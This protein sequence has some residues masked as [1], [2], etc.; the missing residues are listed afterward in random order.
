MSAPLAGRLSIAVNGERSVPLAVAS[1][2]ERATAPTEPR[3]FALGWIGTR[4]AAAERR[5]VTVLCCT[6][7]DRSTA[8]AAPSATTSDLDGTAHQKQSVR[9]LVEANGGYV[10]Q[11]AGRTLLAVWGFPRAHPDMTRLALSAAIAIPAI[12]SPI[13]TARVTLDA[14]LI[15]IS[16][17]DEAGAQTLDLTG[18]T[19]DAAIAMQ[20]HCPDGRV[21][22]SAAM[23]DL[24]HH[25][26]EYRPAA[27]ATTAMAAVFEYTGPGAKPGADSV[28]CLIGHDAARTMLRS[29]IASIA[30]GNSGSGVLV[31]G[32]AG[33]GKSV[34]IDEARRL[35]AAHSALWIEADCHYETRSV[36]LQPVRE[37]LMRLLSQPVSEGSGVDSMQAA[38]E[39]KLGRDGW[40][41]LTRFLHANSKRPATDPRHRSGDTARPMDLV[42]E[43]VVALT[44]AS[45]VVVAVEDLHWADSATIEFVE[46]IA[47]RLAGQA[48]L[49][50]VVSSRED[51]SAHQGAGRPLRRVTVQ[52]LCHEQ[53]VQVAAARSEARHLPDQALDDIARRSEGV[54]LYAIEL[55]RFHAASGPMTGPMAPLDSPSG[56]HMLF[57]ARLD[58]LGELKPLVQA[59]AIIGRRFET[60]ALAQLLGVSRGQLS[61]ALGG[62]VERGVIE[63]D[64]TLSFAAF[65]FTH[66]L[67]RDAAYATIPRELRDEMHQRAAAILAEGFHPDGNIASELI[68]SHFELACD[69][70]GA[71]RWWRSAAEAAIAI[72][73][74]NGAIGH[75]RSALRAAEQA[76]MAISKACRVDTMRLLAL[77]LSIVKG[78][79]SPEAVEA[80]QRCLDLAETNERDAPLVDFD[81]LWGLHS[82]Y[83]VRGDIPDA[84]DIGKRLLAKV[85]DDA[86][87]SQ[88]LL[89]HRIN[90][91]TQL[92]AGQLC[93]AMASYGRVLEIYRPERDARLRFEYGSDQRA[94]ALTH[95]AWAATIMG[96]VAQARADRAAALRAVRM[97]NHPHTTA[98]VTCVLAAAAQT[99]G[100]RE[101]AA[102]MAATGRMVAD[103]H[104]FNYWSAWADLVLGWLEGSKDPDR[105]LAMVAKAIRDYQHTGA[106][107]ALPYAYLLFAEIAHG[108]GRTANALAA[109]RQ[110]RTLADSRG[111]HLYGAEIRRL[112][113]DVLMTS[114]GKTAPRAEAEARAAL[115]Q[116]GE[117][118]TR[119]NANLFAL[120][121][122][123]TEQRLFGRGD[124]S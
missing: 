10:I 80:Y 107:Q 45:P 86:N 98:H 54:P 48:G 8:P 99:A 16:P 49:G 13:A 35:S 50:L 114:G 95:R 66:S 27:A 88:H 116:A 6:I 81:V 38:V 33:I 119:Q 87:G 111:L 41:A 109:L 59:A 51:L 110:A 53:I 23:R 67:L 1:F 71:Y 63:P 46:R 34:L 3:D 70:A 57:A 108:G 24:T 60:N 28:T 18:A 90:A 11:S 7:I 74:T 30:G 17:L 20:L 14:G 19:V 100:E 89:A 52:R 31:E 115:T 44:A 25:H 73:E 68:A 2:G 5:L 76:D 92:L 120:R 22:V 124:A 103:E 106:G 79:A 93:D 61:P 105:G 118:A 36:P 78:N 117:L 102:A 82:C 47:D 96:D 9:E 15:M 29:C 37:A 62:L 32:E 113:A 40:T 64:A 42:I 21:L 121:V 75:L 123:A 101:T 84:L 26:A 55:V 43:A 91:L 69:Y 39:S 122:T 85:A 65:R 12:L 58:Q 72:S 94:L 77:Q 4:F 56:L 97:L 104:G 83:L 112:T